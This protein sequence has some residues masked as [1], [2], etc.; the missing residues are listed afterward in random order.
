[1]KNKDIEKSLKRAVDVVAENV[2]TDVISFCDESKEDN[3]I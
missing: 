1:M 2:F 3:I